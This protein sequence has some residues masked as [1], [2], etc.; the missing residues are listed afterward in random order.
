[1][2]KT[3]IKSVWDRE[4]A[5][6]LSGPEA[7]ERHGFSS[8]PAITVRGFLAWGLSEVGEFEEAEMW[9]RQGIELSGQVKNLFSTAIIQACSGVA[10]LRHGKID[11]A[12]KQL[13]EGY[14]L[15]READSRSE[16]E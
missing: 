8:V 14:A 7:L 3:I 13:Q 2:L 16:F 1:M 15:S 12:F 9:A 10:Y 4:V 6:Q 5:Q 11:A